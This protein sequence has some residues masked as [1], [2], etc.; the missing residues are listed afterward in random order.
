MAEPL[1]ILFAGGGTGGH[2]YPGLAV[3]AE[4]RAMAPEADIVFYVTRRSIDRH[5]LEG[6]PYR[7]QYEDARGFSPRPWRWP[8][9]VLKLMENLGRARRYLGEFQPHAVIGLGGFGS[10]AAVRAAQKLGRPNFLL[11]PDLIVGRANRKLAVGATGVFCQFDETTRGLRTGGRVEVVGCPIR[12]D[13]LNVDRREACAK[14]GLN[15]TKKTLTITGASG[16]A[17]NIN[18]AFMQLASHWSQFADWQILHLTGRDLY[19]E[20]KQGIG[21]VPSYHL[22]DYVHEMGQVYAATDLIVARA[23]AGTVAEITALGLPSVLMPYP[24]HRDRHQ[25]RHAELLEN[26]GAAIL[27]RDQ[28]KPTLNAQALWSA[29]SPLMDDEPRRQQMAEAAKAYGH[30]K[31]A[32]SVATSILS[33]VGWRG[34]T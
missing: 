14:L 8:T 15:P 9:F 10:Y 19:D 17:R 5:V 20:V 13:L 23:G 3:A 1:R 33:T 7:T 27:V 11:N 2:L 24:Y 21:V 28:I 22:R 12:M 4:L 34:G 26:A 29:L 30:P 25:E 6:Q 31:A 32:R 16:G 18:Q